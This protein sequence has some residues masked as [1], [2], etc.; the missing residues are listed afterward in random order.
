M[1]VREDTERDITVS[2]KTRTGYDK[3]ITEE[4]TRTLNEAEPDFISLHARTFKQAYE[5]NADWEAIRRAANVS[6][7]PIIGNGDVKSPEDIQK[8]FKLTGGKGVMVGRGA[9]GKPWVFGGEGFK[10]GGVETGGSRLGPLNQTVALEHAKLYV[11]FKGE[12]RFYEMR[13]HLMGYFAGFRGAKGLR[14][15]MSKVSCLKDVVEQL[16]VKQL[17]G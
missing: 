5:G 15:K 16:T 14:V 3:D 11:K 9:V 8:M 12:K 13:K 6:K 17:R 10:L 2:V 4:W 1:G 7:V